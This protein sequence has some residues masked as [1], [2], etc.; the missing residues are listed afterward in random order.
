MK[1]KKVYVVTGLFL[2]VIAGLLA[3]F[4]ST[5]AFANTKKLYYCGPLPENSS[6]KTIEGKNLK[7]WG[8]GTPVFVVTAFVP[9][10]PAASING[11]GE[12]LPGCYVDPDQK[13]FL[14]YE[15]LEVEDAQGN[16]K[17][18]L[19]AIVGSEGAQADPLP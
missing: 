1:E 18:L 10:E 14:V 8:I 3:I 2:L 5:G 12:V 16:Y 19:A 7:L 11:G 6:F 17:V 13:V 9:G 4:A 15:N